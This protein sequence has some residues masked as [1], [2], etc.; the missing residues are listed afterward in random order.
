MIGGSSKKGPE[1]FLG[2]FGK[3]S[4]KLDIEFQVQ[5]ASLA[6]FLVDKAFP[7]HLMQHLR[8]ESKMI[9]LIISS[10][11]TLRCLPSRVFSSTGLHSRA[12]AKLSSFV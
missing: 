1:F 5:V 2:G 4:G 10:M 6:C 8:T 3:G 11:P 7:D 9:Y 12:S